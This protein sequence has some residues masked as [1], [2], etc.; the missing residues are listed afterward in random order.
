MITV[1][2]AVTDTGRRAVAVLD[3]ATE[4]TSQAEELKTEVSRFLEEMRRAA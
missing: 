1:N 2:E 4:L 3:A